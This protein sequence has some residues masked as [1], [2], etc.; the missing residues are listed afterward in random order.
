MLNLLADENFP[1]PVLRGLAK[2][3][4]TIDIVRIQDVGLMAMD[5]PF[6]LAWAALNGRIVLSH[7][8]ATFPDFAY[9]RIRTGEKMAGV[10]IFRRQLPFRQ[11]I[12]ELLI[13]D[14]CTNTEDWSGQVV[15]FPL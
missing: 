1:G 3:R 2:I 15:Y 11:I 13:V 10:F 4:P 9:D 14:E 12:E 5:D 6:I 8:R 7:D